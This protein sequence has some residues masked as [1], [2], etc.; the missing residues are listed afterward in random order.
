MFTGIITATAKVIAADK[1]DEGC[2]LVLDRPA[3]WDDVSLGESIAVNGIC[4]T[5]SA[6]RGQELEFFL[7]PET[8]HK[9]SFGHQVP[10]M[11]N[12]ERAL[13]VNDRFGGHFVQG[14]VDEVG[15]VDSINTTDGYRLAIK[16]NPENQELVVYKGSI[17]VDGVAL[18]VAKLDAG[19]L[20]VAVIPHTLE[21]TTLGD[22]RMGDPVN[23]EFDILGKYVINSLK[24]K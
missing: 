24:A 8:L 16:F 7:T 17:T 23:L 15:T 4:L 6:L 22:A 18:T 5:V 2:R 1:N 11:I 3:D 13:S 20:E 19:S 12:L 14:H 9:T 10:K 21:H